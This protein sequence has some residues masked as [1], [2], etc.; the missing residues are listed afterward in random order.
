MGILDKKKPAIAAPAPTADFR[1][2][3]STDIPVLPD[4]TS[5]KE[6]DVK[7]PLLSPYA[8]A[9]IHW[10]DNE[11]EVIYELLEP[12]LDQREKSLLESIERGLEELI[13]ISFLNIN[14]ESAVISYLEKNTK[15][16]LA[17]LGLKPPREVFMKLM[18]YIYRDFVGLNKIEAIGTE[19]TWINNSMFMPP[20]RISDLQITSKI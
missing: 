19:P 6:V 13:N 17:E 11:K 10:D 18:Y 15:V 9:H 16:L 2:E 20:I 8:Y 14:E 12:P 5:K 1:I 4:F 3:K 7:Y